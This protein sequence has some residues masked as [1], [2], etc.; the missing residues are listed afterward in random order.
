MA[1]TPLYINLLREQSQYSSNSSPY[2]S[3][4]CPDDKA[5]SPLYIHLREHTK[6]S[7][8][9]QY[10]CTQWSLRRHDS[11]SSP[12]VSTPWSILPLTAILYI[13]FLQNHCR[14][15][16]LGYYG[17]NLAE[18]STHAKYGFCEDRS[19]LSAYLESN[20]QITNSLFA[21]CIFIL[22]LMIFVLCKQD[23][24]DQSQKAINKFC[25][26]A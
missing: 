6:Y 8:L 14:R 17:S 26:T 9:F 5:R 3:T 13:N 21:S 25:K 4:P 18:N 15:R 2:V 10:V 1:R 16:I 12:Y 11:I 23:V 19:S 20:L 22:I 24:Y 7:S